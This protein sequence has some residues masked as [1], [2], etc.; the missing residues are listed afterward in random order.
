MLIFFKKFIQKYLQSVKQVGS[1]SGPTFGPK[2]GPDLGPNC[3][4]RLSDDTKELKC[5]LPSV[6]CGHMYNSL[7]LG[8]LP[9]FVHTSSENPDKSGGMLRRI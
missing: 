4:K 6:Q 3:L 5:G 1:R 2:V 9:F 7:S 8:P